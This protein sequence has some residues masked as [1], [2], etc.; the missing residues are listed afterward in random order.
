MSDDNTY[1]TYPVDDIIE[2]LIDTDEGDCL[3]LPETIPI[4]RDDGSFGWQIIHNAWDG[5]E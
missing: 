3:C 5:R 4:P 2:H 1:H